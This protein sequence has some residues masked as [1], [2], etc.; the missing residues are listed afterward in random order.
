LLFWFVNG[1]LTRIFDIEKQ[2]L[3]M[4]LGTNGRTIRAIEKSAHYLVESPVKK[5]F[6]S[7][8]Q[9]DLSGT[10]V[11]QDAFTY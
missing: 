3:A 1:Y 10:P 11:F 4:R 7:I 9:V 8:I 2:G 6:L 5:A